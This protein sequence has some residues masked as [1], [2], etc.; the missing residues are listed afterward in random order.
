MTDDKKSG[1]DQIDEGP[2]TSDA[3]AST[4]GGSAGDPAD[5]PSVQ[6]LMARFGDAI[7]RHRV[8]AGDQHVVWVDA[9][10]SHEILA[11]LR[12][13]GEHLY[14]MM[15]DVTG[16]DYGGGRP[17]EVVYQMY[18]TTYRRVLRV[19]CALAVDALEIDSVYDLWKGVNWLEREVYD[20]FGVTFSGH[21]DLR[22]ILMPDDYAEGHPLRKDFPLRGRFSRAEQT[23]RAL[24]QEVER[25]YLI[26]DLETGLDPQQASPT[27]V[28]STEDA[29]GDR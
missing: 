26:E 10:R 9:A 17:V 13:D 25:F 19:R 23:R 14:D 6:A 7:V 27:E 29:G 1:L 12:D 8:N 22:R 11:W 20:L 3:V 15:S 28:G 2:A 16:V 24:N 4:G 21:P 5:H 18:S